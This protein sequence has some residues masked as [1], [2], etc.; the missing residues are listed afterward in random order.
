MH[1]P[2][3]TRR[4]SARC[5]SARCEPAAMI[6]RPIDHGHRSARRRDRDYRRIITATCSPPARRRHNTSASSTQC[7]KMP[8]SARDEAH[9]LGA[10]FFW[11]SWAAAAERPGD[12]ISYTSNWPHEPLVGNTPT[13]SIFL[14]T[15]ISIFVLLAGIGGAGLVLCPRVRRVAA[16]H[17]ADRGLATTDVFGSATDHAFDARDGQI[18]FRRHGNVLRAG[19]A[20]DRHCALRGRR[21]GP[22]RPAD[23]RIF[24][25]RGHPHLAHAARGAVDC[26][27]MAGDRALCGSVAGRARAEVPAPRRELPVHQPARDRGRLV[28]RRMARHQSPSRV[29]HAQFL[30]RPPGL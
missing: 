19:A 1:Y 10:F 9:V 17:G 6:A 2:S 18:F 20:R 27:R 25:L 11:T 26:D 30:V 3:P 12:T 29:R 7:R 5:S 8:S 14:W 28:R 21:P 15:F 23:G 24:P 4:A 16:R 22:L 13:G